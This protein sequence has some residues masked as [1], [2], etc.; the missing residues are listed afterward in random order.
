M[1]IDAVG[2]QLLEIKGWRKAA[3]RNEWRHLM[4]K[5]K[6]RKGL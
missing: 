3:N 5:A 6:A 1:Y 4:R 2:L